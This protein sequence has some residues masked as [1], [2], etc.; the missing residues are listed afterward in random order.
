M[1][2]AKNNIM[3]TITKAKVGFTISQFNSVELITETVATKK[4]VP[5][6]GGKAEESSP[7]LDSRWRANNLTSKKV[8]FIARTPNAC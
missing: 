1:N 8:P 3:K 4:S 2:V 6:T 7:G 5:V